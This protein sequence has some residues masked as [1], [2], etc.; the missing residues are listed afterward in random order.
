LFIVTLSALCDWGKNKQYKILHDA[1]RDEK[2][3]VIRGNKGLS[4]TQ[5]AWNLV[6]GDIIT[7]EAGMRIPADCILLDGMDIKCDESMYRGGR[8]ESVKKLSE[9]NEQHV[10]ENPD[11]FLLTRSLVLSGSGRAVVCAVGKRTRWFRE[12]PV[13]DLEDDN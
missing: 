5:L 11:P 1:I 12:N 6:V 8:K 13:E 4:E 3:A 9:S 2:V 10:S 7:I